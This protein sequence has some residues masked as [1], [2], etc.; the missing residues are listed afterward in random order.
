MELAFCF[1][2][3]DE[4]ELAG[5][6]VRQLRQFYPCSQIVCCT[7][8]IHY[9]AFTQLTDHYIEG[10]QLFTYGNGGAW[11]K[12]MFIAALETD[13]DAA[14]F[15]DPDSYMLRRFN[16]FPDADAA[17]TLMQWRDR[18]YLYLQGG[19]KLIK[20][21]AIEKIIDSGLLDASEYVN[22]AFGYQRYSDEHRYPSEAFSDRWFISE[23][24]ILGDIFTR[25]NLSFIDW[26]E[27]YCRFRES[28]PNPKSYAV[29][30]PVKSLIYAP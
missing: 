22:G 13:C 17:G 18:D 21:R 23:D 6:L 11:I 15:L 27:V 5:R 7:D 25:L 24:H 30:H 3:Y 12:R 29:I 8:G 28:C 20:R 1:T 16:Y 2:L 14:V 9:P 19:C 4:I 26:P 10:E